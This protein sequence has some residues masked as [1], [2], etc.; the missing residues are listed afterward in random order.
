MTNSF[1]ALA[2]GAVILVAGNRWT[3]RMRRRFPIVTVLGRG[4]TLLAL[5]FAIGP[6][7]AGMLEGD[8]MQQLQPI[9][10]VL[11][12]WSGVVVGLQCQ[13]ALIRAIP[14]V[15]WRWI[16]FDLAFSFL[17]SVVAAGLIARIWQPD[18]PA[19]AHILLSGTIAAMAIG[20]NPETR[21][22]GICTDAAAMR[23]TVLVQAG[24]GALAICTIAIATIALQCAFQDEQGTVVFAPYGGAL[25][26]AVEI[27]SVLVVS[28]AAY[29]ILRDFHEDDARTT[30]IAIGALCLLS[31]I[32]VSFGGSGLLS[33]MLLGIMIGLAGKRLRG[34]GQLLSHAEPLVASGC[35]FFAG[36]TLALP[37]AAGSITGALT[38]GA[39]AALLAIARRVLK[40]LIMHI[41]LADESASIALDSPAARAPVRQAPLAIV[42]LLA[43]AIQDSSG[44]A[45]QLL[46]LAVLISLLSTIATTLPW[47]ARGA[48][49]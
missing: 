48:M 29:G 17:L 43:F 27:A 25:V 3:E 37:S 26:L 13:P 15:L 9:L 5:G 24:A 30:L 36:V 4:W 49:A 42:V 20:W 47:R 12:T 34:L 8:R 45:D 7:G 11:L 22:L 31:G 46:G 23:L 6:H 18:T 40:P 32:A 39:I 19:A 38:I 28:F 35:F 10:L 44:L 21:S 2:L 33:G 16:T 1:L 14:R 41:A